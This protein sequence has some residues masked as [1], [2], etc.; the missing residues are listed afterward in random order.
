MYGVGGNCISPTTTQPS[1]GGGETSS[2]NVNPNNGFCPEGYFLFEDKCINNS[3]KPFAD[4]LNSS[5]FRDWFL[6]EQ[7]QLVYR[8][9][10]PTE[11][12]VGDN[13]QIINIFKNEGDIAS[14]LHCVNFFDTNRNGI[15]DI[16]EPQA[17]FNKQ[18]EP[19]VENSINTI[20]QI[21]LNISPNTYLIGGRCDLQ[22]SSIE[23]TASANTIIIKLREKE[24]FN[25]NIPQNFSNLFKIIA[26]SLLVYLLHFIQFFIDDKLLQNIKRFFALTFILIVNLLISLPFFYFIL[27]DSKLTIIYLILS[28]VTFVIHFLLDTDEIL[29][30]S[31]VVNLVI[32]SFIFT[33]FLTIILLK[34]MIKYIGKDD[35]NCYFELITGDIFGFPIE[36][37]EKVI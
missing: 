28:S 15:I 34:W 3:L 27:R 31:K 4:L 20:L 24:G 14:E 23:N 29:R 13:I 30:F 11:A 21:P 33:V 37:C 17:S 9:I 8:I 19:F 5:T 10:T 26:F 1:V 36:D 22:N 32:S 12:F 7:P 18:A 16:E 6:P 25:L 2:T 35:K